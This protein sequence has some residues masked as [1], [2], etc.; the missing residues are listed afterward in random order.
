M[1][2]FDPIKT[3]LQRYR[4]LE[5]HQNPELAQQL[6]NIQLWQKKRMEHTHA[7]L[8]ANPNHLL[9]SQYF[10]NR[11]YGGPDFEQLAG[12]FERVLVV[13]HK[14]AKLAPESAVHTGTLG[15][16][17]AVMAI[18]LDEDLARLVYRDFGHQG[19]LNDVVMIRA[20]LAANQQ[21]ARLHQMD[22]LDELGNRLDKY[23][24]SFII[25]S[26]FKMAKGTAYKHNFAPLY[27]FTAEGFAAM[28]PLASA[29]D[30]IGVFTA[31]ERDTVERVHAGDPYPFRV[32]HAQGIEHASSSSELMGALSN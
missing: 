22:L 23:V 16:E 25:Q 32:A 27:D 4:Q 28:K 31:A 15:I 3:L 30:F 29:E 11:L 17:L 18:E 24:R 6:A 2:A 19:E 14:V 26:A 8:F 7:E 10:L 12:Q 20:Y 9:I 21:D 5:H 1:S 13:A